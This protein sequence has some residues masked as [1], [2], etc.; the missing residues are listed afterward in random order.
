MEH[1]LEANVCGCGWVRNFRPRNAVIRVVYRFLVQR[2]GKKCW[3]C[4]HTRN[5]IVH[6]LDGDPGNMK[7]ENLVL[8]CRKHN[9]PSHGG[10]RL[11]VSVGV[12]KRDGAESSRLG[13]G[14]KESADGRLT[15]GAVE[16]GRMSDELRASRL[17]EPLFRGWVFEQLTPNAGVE[18]TFNEAMFGGAEH[19]GCSPQTAYRYLQKMLAHNGPLKLL[20][21]PRGKQRLALKG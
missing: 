8:S 5:L 14:G 17:F 4:P 10:S 16:S 7:P 9:L 3:R 6:H 2:D 13:V 21:G 1:A 19:V 12:R 18:L 20:P 15:A 11:S